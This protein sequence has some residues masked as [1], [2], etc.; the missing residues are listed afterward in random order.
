MDNWKKATVKNYTAH[1]LNCRLIVP[2]TNRHNKLERQFKRAARRK[3]K[4]ETRRDLFN[5]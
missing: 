2:H 5:A 1:N 4:Q 3:L